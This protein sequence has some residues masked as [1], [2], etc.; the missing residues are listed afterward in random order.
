WNALTFAI[1]WL[2]THA[3]AVIGGVWL[4]GTAGWFLWQGYTAVKFSRR[5]ALATP[6]P[7]ELQQQADNLARAMGLAHRPPVM[8]VRDVI[9]PMLWGIGSNT[10]LLFP[11][12]LLARLDVA[13]RETLIAHELAHFRRGD[14]W[15]RAFELF[16]SG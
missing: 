13:A 7:A 6:A 10:R 1:G 14:H 8:L 11:M 2:L 15:V 5:L 4:A 9:S 16:V 3:V 12:K